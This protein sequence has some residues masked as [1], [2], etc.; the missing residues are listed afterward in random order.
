MIKQFLHFFRYLKY[1]FK[2]K[3]NIIKFS[4]FIDKKTNLKKNA[5]ILE[6]SSIR[7]S[8]IGISV[9]IKTNCRIQNSEIGNFVRISDDCILYDVKIGRY[10][11]ISQACMLNLVSIGRF[12]SIGYQVIAGRGNHPTDF[13]STSPIFYSKI[14][15]GIVS[16]AEI[17][18]FQERKQI[19]VGND[20]WIGDRVF[21][22]DGVKIG[23]GAVL[24]AGAV[25]VKDIPS[26]SIVGGVPA[27]LIR[28]RFPEKLREE[29][30][31][32]KW[33]NLEE[34]KLREARSLM[35]KTNIHEFINWAKNI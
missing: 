28:Y 21:I 26:Y 18:A 3:S 19:I 31:K 14:A 9:V 12:S 2:Y 4:V 17:N 25:V 27:R 30:L 10:S 13:V 20:V 6:G 34:R 24:A 35:V 32:I 22:K 16:F 33:W 11:Y 1:K 7:N 29:L 23:D 5:K 8:H 15:H